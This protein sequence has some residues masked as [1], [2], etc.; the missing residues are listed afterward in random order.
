M[1]ARSTKLGKTLVVH[2]ASDVLRDHELQTSAIKNPARDAMKRYG[3]SGAQIN[4]LMSQSPSRILGLMGEEL[5]T[6][7]LPLFK[8]NEKF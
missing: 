4:T 8:A 1:K 6:A 2:F 5:E 3:L 7:S